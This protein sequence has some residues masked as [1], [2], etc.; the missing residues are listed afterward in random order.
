[1]IRIRYSVCGYGIPVRVQLGPHGGGPQGSFLASDRQFTGTTVLY[2]FHSLTAFHPQKAVCSSRG[3]LYLYQG[4]S[5]PLTPT[6]L[7]SPALASFVLSSPF[8][9]CSCTTNPRRNSSSS[10]G[11]SLLFRRRLLRMARAREAYLRQQ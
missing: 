4:R 9:A 1:M 7:Y 11:L 2:L 3:L 10:S 5:S 8:S 6:L